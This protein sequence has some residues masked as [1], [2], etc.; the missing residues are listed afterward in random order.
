MDAERDRLVA[1]LATILEVSRAMGA[2]RDLGRLLDLIVS[3]T[4]T[5]IEADRTSLFLVDGER[6]EL[7][8]TIAQRSTAIRL[9]LGRGIAGSVA[10]SGETINIPDA[11]NDPRFDS[12]NDRKSGYTTRSILCM[13]LRNHQGATV[14]VIQALNK[15]GGSPFN[16]YDEQVL[17]ALCAQAA[18]AI[19]TARL[20]AAER[21]RERLAHELELAAGIQAGL[22]PARAP[23]APGWS[24]A[25]FARPCDETGGDYYDYLIGNRGIDL[26]VGD[27]SGHGIAAA[28]IMSTARAF[29]RAVHDLDDEDPGAIVTRL[30]RLL[31][32]DLGDDTFMSLVTCRLGGDGAVSYVSAGHEA[33]LIYRRASGT[34]AF[35]GDTGLLLGVLGDEVYETV[36]AESLAPGDLVLCFTDG[37]WECADA[38]GDQLGLDRVKAIVAETGPRGAIA[39]RD[40]LVAASM[41]Q[42]GGLP[43]R[44]DMT[45]VIAERR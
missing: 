4:T 2:E 38:A 6:H 20:I 43:P 30:N 34:V 22:L 17:S 37:I 23:E 28:L 31:E 21:E 45:L 42:L 15:R 36:R 33:P 16:D 32:H 18:V 3:A 39:V 35:A 40:A 13:A 11:Q 1:D 9:P 41:S 27:V 7:W 5:L 8:T 29:L 12:D 19:E 44:D 24:F 26:I 14:G 25:S 10:E